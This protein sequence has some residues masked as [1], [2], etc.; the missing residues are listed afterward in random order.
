MAV[1][2]RTTLIPS[3]LDLLASWLPAQPWYQA[4]GQAPELARAGGFRLDD[5]DGEVGIE[6][7]VVTDT[8]SD[9][10]VT[11]LVPLTYRAIACDQ[12]AGGLIGNAGPRV[13]GHRWIY[14]GAHDPVLVAA[15]VA[16]LQGDAQAQAQNVSDTPDLTVSSVPVTSGPLD[17][18]TSAV[19][20]NEPDGTDVRVTIAGADGGPGE[21][22]IVRLHRV[23]RPGDSAAA[24]GQPQVVAAWR[25]PDG[26]DA[27]GTVASVL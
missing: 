1:I 22:L 15:L 19:A 9:P 11:Y 27:R 13:L 6:F 16:L 4:T 17:V 3:K 24:A 10:A 12:A 18:L 14:D 2:H 26:T 20:A 23:L 21:D 8:S 5:P 25:L 7:S